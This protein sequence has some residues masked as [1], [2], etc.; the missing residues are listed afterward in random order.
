MEYE[1]SCF[2]V[3]GNDFGVVLPGGP[4]FACCLFDVSQC[5]AFIKKVEICSQIELVVFLFGKMLRQLGSNTSIGIMVSVQKTSQKGVSCI[6]ECGVVWYDHKM[7]WI[8]SAQSP[9]V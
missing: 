3:A 4:F 9:S 6:V 5:S 2:E 8:S 1:V 7:K